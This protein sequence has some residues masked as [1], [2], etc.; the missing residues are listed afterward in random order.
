MNFRERDRFKRQKHE[1]GDEAGEHAEIAPSPDKIR[2][3]FGKPWQGRREGE[4]KCLDKK[5][6][7]SRGEKRH[8]RGEDASLGLQ[9]ECKRCGESGG[10]EHEPER[11]RREFVA[12]P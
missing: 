11:V 7:P 8:K 2:G 10:N 3:D 9:R 4:L 6:Y 5:D 1:R 12:E